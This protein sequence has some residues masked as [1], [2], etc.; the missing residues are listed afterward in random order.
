MFKNIVHD[1]KIVTYYLNRFKKKLRN[2]F[3]NYLA[4]K[5]CN[6]NYFY[7]SIIPKELFYP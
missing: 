4:P 3:S 7:N 6:I 5:G 1:Y 2:V